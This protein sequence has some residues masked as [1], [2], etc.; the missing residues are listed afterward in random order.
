VLVRPGRPRY[1]VAGTVHPLRAAT[2]LD[3]QLVS[4]AVAR[5][6]AMTDEARQALG[7]RREIRIA[8]FP[9]KI[10]RESRSPNSAFRHDARPDQ[11]FVVDRGCVC[12]TIVAGKQIGGSRTGGRT[13]V[14]HGDLSVVGTS[15]SRYV[16]RFE[17]M[18][19]D[20][21]C[22]SADS[23]SMTPQSYNRE[24]ATHIGLPVDN[25]SGSHSRLV[26]GVL[27]G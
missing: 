3:P 13:E 14:R 5:L 24:I 19:N 8:T 27:L 26:D 4:S 18:L 12:G 7:D 10:R 1:E 22:Q 21:P 2:L 6:V 11:C 15:D 17:M 16:F 25:G 9:S 23:R 20:S